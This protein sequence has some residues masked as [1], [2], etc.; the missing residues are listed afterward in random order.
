MHPQLRNRANRRSYVSHNSPRFPES[1]STE[2]GQGPASLH[3]KRSIPVPAANQSLFFPSL[4]TSSP[5]AIVP[6]CT[7]KWGSSSSTSLLESLESRSIR[8]LG[9]RIHARGKKSRFSDVYNQMGRGRPVPSPESWSR[10][11]W[12]TRFNPFDILYN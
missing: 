4:T 12:Y 2:V 11:A 8:C 6:L 9:C 1:P 10:Q 5:E 7:T 3:L